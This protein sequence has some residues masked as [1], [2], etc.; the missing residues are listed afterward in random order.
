MVPSGSS[1]ATRNRSRQPHARR[2]ES[3]S[4]VGPQA[5]ERIE[6]YTPRLSPWPHPGR[7]FTELRRPSYVEASEG[8][9]GHDAHDHDPIVPPAKPPRPRRAPTPVRTEPKMSANVRFCPPNRAGKN[10]THR[11]ATSCPKTPENA[12]ICP[13]LPGPT[14]PEKTNPTSPPLC[15]LC[16]PLRPSSSNSPTISGNTRCFSKYKVLW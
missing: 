15:V 14:R 16:P 1:A 2:S 3:I 8:T 11:R 4:S 7:I 6:N 5:A 13:V 10:R 9:R 12:R